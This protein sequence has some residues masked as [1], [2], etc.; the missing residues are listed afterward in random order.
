[1][2]EYNHIKDKL[3]I[4]VSEY[5]HFCHR[6]AIRNVLYF[7]GMV[8]YELLIKNSID[9]TIAPPTEKRNIF[10]PAINNTKPVM[11]CLENCF[12][13]WIYDISWENI[14]DELNKGNI[15]LLNTDVF[16]LRYSEYYLKEHGSHIVILLGEKNNYYYV[17]DWYEPQYFVGWIHKCELLLARTSTNSYEKNHAYSGYPINCA[18]QRFSSE[19]IN[20][21]YTKTELAY[22]LLNDILKRSDKKQLEDEKRIITTFCEIPKLIASNDISDSQVTEDLFLLISERK[23]CIRQLNLFANE[24][25]EVNEICKDLSNILLEMTLQ[26]QSMEFILLRNNLKNTLINETKWIEHCM[27]MLEKKNKFENRLSKELKRG[28]DK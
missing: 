4:F 27:V 14:K 16:Y 23:L 10:Y 5:K 25:G 19:E 11:N 6:N 3:P 22:E 13:E 17:V 20:K 26:L 2:N 21:N 12:S 7:S 18:W 15:I 24:V 8:D 1:M 9:L 28:S